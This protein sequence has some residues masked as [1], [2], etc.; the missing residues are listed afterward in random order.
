MLRKDLEASFVKEF[1]KEPF[2]P[3]EPDY[4]FDVWL[5]SMFYL[6]TPFSPKAREVKHLFVKHFS[7]CE[8]ESEFLEFC[9]E[10]CYVV[11]FFN[12]ISLVL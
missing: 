7:C 1:V 4:M 5:L 12:V 9:I 3:C 10:Y 6:T 8:L 2:Y 11:S